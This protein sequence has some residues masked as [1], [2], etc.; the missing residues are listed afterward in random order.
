[1]KEM[2]LTL[3]YIIA[4]FGYVI[5]LLGIIIPAALIVYNFVVGAFAGFSTTV[6]VTNT[7]ILL[8]VLALLYVVV[9]NVVY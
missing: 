3:C 2:L 1:M 8:Y 7:F 5:A 9:Y 4:T 6:R